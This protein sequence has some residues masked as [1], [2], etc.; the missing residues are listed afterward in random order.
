MSKGKGVSATRHH[1]DITRM[2]L[3]ALISG[4]L[5][6]LFLFTQDLKFSEELDAA[7]KLETQSLSPKVYAEYQNRKANFDWCVVDPI[8]FKKAFDEM[9][10]FFRRSDAAVKSLNDAIQ[11][12]ESALPAPYSGSINGFN[13]WRRWAQTEFDR[14]QYWRLIVDQEV[15]RKENPK[16]EI[17][18]YLNFKLCSQ[19]NGITAILTKFIRYTK[20]RDY[21][22]L[23]DKK[24][25]YLLDQMWVFYQHQDFNVQL[26]KSYLA[27]LS[28]NAEMRWSS[29]YAYLFDRIRINQDLPQR[30]GTQIE[31]FDGRCSL[32]E[33]EDVD[34][35]DN[36]RKR[37][38][39]EPLSVY[40]SSFP[41]CLNEDPR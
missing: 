25:T 15:N 26:Q 12:W 41:A 2:T 24:K 39:L 32:G 8:N 36:R 33:I 40:L 37:H 3:A 19:S 23:P 11:R 22:D 6:G 21:I 4:T 31:I 1:M 28:A 35:I 5:L 17:K 30:F 20:S 27:V 16:M 14:D 10:L 34:M 29:A 38:G 7:L 18:F 9:T 13:D